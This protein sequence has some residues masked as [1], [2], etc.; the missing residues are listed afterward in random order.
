MTRSLPVSASEV[1]YAKLKSKHPSVQL[2]DCNNEDVIDD[3]RNFEVDPKTRTGGLI[4]TLFS[5]FKVGDR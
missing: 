2:R 5:S 1:G 4:L 3:I